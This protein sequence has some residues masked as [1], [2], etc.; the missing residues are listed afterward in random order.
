MLI[1]SKYESWCNRCGKVRIAIG[2][3]CEWAPPA[4]GV[5]C[6]TCLGTSPPAQ[7]PKKPAT[8]F[9]PATFSRH[10][11]DVAAV[12]SVPVLPPAL[13]ALEG[14]EVQFVRMAAKTSTPAIDS[15]W[16]KYEKVKALAIGNRIVPEQRVALKTA[17]VILVTAIF[18]EESAYVV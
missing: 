1:T 18:S 15:A 7:L 11:D 6:L 2:D 16:S 9:Q 4:K 5:T 3:R 8:S 10:D 13:A 17:L 12:F 14:L